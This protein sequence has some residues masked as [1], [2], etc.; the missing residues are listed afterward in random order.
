V[1]VFWV[2]FTLAWCSYAAFVGLTCF[3]LRRDWGLHLIPH[4]G[5]SVL[6][7]VPTLVELVN[8]NL[9]FYA[10]GLVYGLSLGAMTLLIA[11]WFMSR[12]LPVRLAKLS[13]SISAVTF[14]VAVFWS[15]GGPGGFFL[16]FLFF[17]ARDVLAAH[18]VF[19]LLFFAAV[20]AAWLGI[21]RFYPG[22][23][24][25]PPAAPPPESDPAAKRSGCSWRLALNV[26][27]ALL[28]LFWLAQWS[29]PRPNGG[30]VNSA[31]EPGMSPE[32]LDDTEILCSGHFSQSWQPFRW[33]WN[34]TLKAGD[35]RFPQT[36]RA[37]RKII[38][39]LVDQYWKGA[40][41]AEIEV[42]LFEP[43]ER[44]WDNAWQLPAQENLL[45]ALKKDETGSGAW[46]FVN[47]SNSWLVIAAGANPVITGAGPD[48]V[49]ESR[50]Y[51]Y[52]QRYA[53][54][55]EAQ[56][57]VLLSDPLAIDSIAGLSKTLEIN[58]VTVVRQA[59]STA[60]N[61]RMEDASTVAL[62]KQM[63]AAPEA[64][65]LNQKTS[66]L[67]TVQMWTSGSPVRQEVL[68]TLMKLAPDSSDLMAWLKDFNARP[69]PAPATP[70]QFALIGQDQYSNFP[71]EL[72]K[73]IADSDNVG[74]MMPLITGALASPDPRM[75]AQVAGALR[76]RQERDNGDFHLGNQ[77]GIAF[78]PMMV[79]LLDDPD[80]DV[81]A[82]AMGC[83]FCM[84][85]EIRKRPDERELNIWA[86]F[87]HKQ[88]P[89]LFPTQLVQ[90]KAWWSRQQ[91]L[92]SK[93]QAELDQLR[94]GLLHYESEDGSPPDD[95]D[96][97]DLLQFL[98]GMNPH[99]TAFIQA[100][101]WEFDSNGEPLDSWGTRLRISLAD[102]RNP[103]VQS[104]GLDKKWDTAD[105]LTGGATR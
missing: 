14:F 73:A 2:A 10:R 27:L 83:L 3:L 58:N 6:I 100:E 89:N 33:C 98:R 4:A 43:S 78:F 86:T 95:G 69:V 20:L 94:Q 102:P 70:S 85:G 18:L 34:V 25:G 49:I 42:A 44:F 48:K 5:L 8:Q 80:H 55:P 97:R 76:Q 61:F 36:V 82:A 68:S 19:G 72:A 21:K 45:V 56:R 51:D 81:R 104:A 88:N 62:L 90:Y 91:A 75:R 28:L 96:P 35:P 93:T 103:A 79:K 52:L 9:I 31:G 40:G 66:G 67:G 16:P 13:R 46:Q 50:T 38:P 47:Q 24:A 99:K 32:M 41:P 74:K 7:V 54:G 53:T 64:H 60:R 87:V 15:L 39:F 22:H 101:T 29:V 105:D 23:E 1:S 12:R 84:S 59:L 57:P 37:R 17:P 63:L 77:L 11:S 92:L 71:W 26:S 30:L 65:D